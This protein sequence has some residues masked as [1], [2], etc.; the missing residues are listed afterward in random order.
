MKFHNNPGQFIIN[1][2]R[3]MKIGESPNCNSMP[4]ET[5]MKVLHVYIHSATFLDQA[6]IKKTVKTR[7]TVTAGRVK[8]R[9]GKG[10]IPLKIFQ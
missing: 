10:G 9:G 6:L 2:S 5:P 4:G 8:K 3:K 7:K 1:L